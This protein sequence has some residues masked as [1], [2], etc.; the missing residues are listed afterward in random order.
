[1]DSPQS[2]QSRWFSEEVAPHEPSLRAY[3]RSSFP[4]VRDVDDVV[5]TSYLRVWRKRAA[6]PIQSARAFLF[7]VARHLAL[8]T[9]RHNRRSPIESV[10]NL[11]GVDV[12]DECPSA[13]ASASRA[14]RIQL[15]VQAIDALPA[16]CREVVIL[17]KLKF[18]PQRDVALRLGIS[19]NG[20]EVQLT[21]GLARCR[22][23]LKKRGVTSFFTDEP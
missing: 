16:R 12:L 2:E 17:R 3:L 9:L 6:A 7:T 10:A 21:R 15:L 20:V 1:M 13:S 5:Q 22:A 14:E 11:A 18:L 4:D 19:E 23:Y 8:D